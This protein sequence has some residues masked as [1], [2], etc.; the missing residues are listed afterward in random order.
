MWFTLYI[1]KQDRANGAYFAFGVK[2][3]RFSGI[4]NLPDVL[5]KSFLH[6]AEKSLRP[7]ILNYLTVPHSYRKR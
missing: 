6:R 1:A 2:E 3:E 4:W 7:T 5:S